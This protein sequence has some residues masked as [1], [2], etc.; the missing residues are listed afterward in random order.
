MTATMCRRRR[1]T[2]WLV[3]T[4]MVVATLTAGAM[5]ALAV[6]TTDSGCFDRSDHVAGRWLGVTLCPY[7]VQGWS[8]VEEEEIWLDRTEDGRL[9][10]DGRLGV[11]ANDWLTGPE[12]YPRGGYWWRTCIVVDDN[13]LDGTAHHDGGVQ[14]H[15]TPWYR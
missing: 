12:D 7:S 14:Y 8:G 6:T 5:P 2:Q 11:R 4:T 3:A 15:C 13:P 9:L 10:W 1:L